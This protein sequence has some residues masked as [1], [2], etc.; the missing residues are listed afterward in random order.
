MK[1]GQRCKV[2]PRL[3]LIKWLREASRQ[4]TFGELQI[5]NVEKHLM[6]NKGYPSDRKEL[7]PFA[8]VE[9]LYLLIGSKTIH[10]WILSEK[11][12]YAPILSQDSEQ[13]V[14]LFSW[15]FVSLL[16]FN[17]TKFIWFKL[18]EISIKLVWWHSL[19]LTQTAASDAKTSH[20]LATST[21][22]L[23]FYL[24]NKQKN[25]LFR[26]FTHFHCKILLFFV[27]FKQKS[28]QD[29]Y[30]LYKRIYLGHGYPCSLQVSDSTL[31]GKAVFPEA[32]LPPSTCWQVGR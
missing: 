28:K 24:Q 5:P 29:Q 27:F 20:L 21:R 15:W 32:L 19:P 14:C 31:F 18:I 13:D 8:Q 16:H 25:I 23:S 10:F 26:Y 30:F 9:V 4:L 3:R 12:K 22:R 2:S 11:Y 1:N 17:F 7:S 6:L